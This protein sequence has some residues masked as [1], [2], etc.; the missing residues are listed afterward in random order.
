M[1]HVSERLLPS[2]PALHF[3]LS[4]LAPPDHVCHGAFAGRSKAVAVRNM[5]S[6][7]A[8]GRTAHARS[9]WLKLEAPSNMLSRSLA[10]RMSHARGYNTAP[11]CSKFIKN[12]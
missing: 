6:V 7:L 11:P 3:C 9:G 1:Y 12:A 8:P 10:R 5:L 4:G 2:R